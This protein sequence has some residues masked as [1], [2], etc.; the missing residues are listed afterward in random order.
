MEQ[1]VPYNEMLRAPPTS[2]E[3]SPTFSQPPKELSLDQA[4]E[5]LAEGMGSLSYAMKVFQTP[6]KRT[7]IHTT[8]HDDNEETERTNE[9]E[10]LNRYLMAIAVFGLTAT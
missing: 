8:E 4:L 3:V 1:L 5:M 7:R 2:A 10:Q 6:Q 9:S